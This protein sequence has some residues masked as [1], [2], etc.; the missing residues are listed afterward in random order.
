M[1]VGLCWY[2]FAIANSSNQ[3]PT[4]KPQTPPSVEGNLGENNTTDTNQN[5]NTDDLVDNSTPSSQVTFNR[6]GKLKFEFTLPE[7]V[8]EFT[9]K[10]EFGSKSWAKMSVNGYVYN[11]F[12]SKTYNSANDKDKPETVE[13]TFKKSEFKSLD[14]RNGYSMNHLYYIN[15]T[16]VPLTQ[17]DYTEGPTDLI[18]ELK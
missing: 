11:Q 17:D 1:I 4:F 10:V 6:V 18:L 5:T 3:D 15:G 7:N 14:L 16:E 9:F 8:D 12:K 2:G 13:L